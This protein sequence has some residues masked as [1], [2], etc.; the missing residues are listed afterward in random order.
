MSRFVEK[1]IFALLL[2]EAR[3]GGYEP[4]YVGYPGESEGVYVDSAER[5]TAEVF[6]VDDADVTFA[7]IGAKADA[8]G[9]FADAFWVRLV[10]GNGEDFISDY[11]G[12]AAAKAILDRVY[13]GIAA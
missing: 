11:G 12:Y 4:R 10:G 2:R 7:R 3:A 6:A 1:Q 9:H 5:A 8:H 13:A